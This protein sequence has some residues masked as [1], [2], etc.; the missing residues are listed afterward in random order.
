MLVAFEQV[1]FSI[2]FHFSFRSR[3]Y[4]ES[5]KPSTGRMGTFRAAAHAFNPYDLLSAMVYAVTLAVGGVGPRDNGEWRKQKKGRGGNYGKVFEQDNVH[6]EP[7]SGMAGPQ[8]TDGGYGYQGFPGEE[9]QQYLAPQG[10]QRPR[11][12]SQTYRPPPDYEI[13]Q[14]SEAASLYPS[15]KR[16]MEAASLYPSHARSHSRD[17]SVDAT[18]MR[19]MV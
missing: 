4:H 7:L 5:E 3:E 14:D 17:P 6:L 8:R 13:V 16:S 1:L 10:Y 18:S 9:S 12:A 2:A 19:E 11:S 15:H